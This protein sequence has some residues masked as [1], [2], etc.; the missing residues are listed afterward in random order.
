VGAVAVA[1]VI[2]RYGLPACQ[3]LVRYWEQG[4][5]T[6]CQFSEDGL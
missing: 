6:S 2:V 1:V 5:L 4:A 3:L